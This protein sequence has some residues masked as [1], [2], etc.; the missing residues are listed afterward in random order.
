MLMQTD[1]LPAPADR[2]E[3]QMDSLERAQRMRL[4]SRRDWQVA[5][6]VM[7]RIMFVIF[8]IVTIACMIAFFPWP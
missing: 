1:K 7:D 4:M 3:I 2:V 8:A 5:A 6:V